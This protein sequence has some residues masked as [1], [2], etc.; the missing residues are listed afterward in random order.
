[1]VEVG[2]G[3][4]AVQAPYDIMQVLFGVLR[5]RH[6]IEVIWVED[7]RWIVQVVD[8]VV[9]CAAIWSALV[10]GTDEDEFLIAGHFRA[11]LGGANA[12][13]LNDEQVELK[14]KLSDVFILP[15]ALVDILGQFADFDNVSRLIPDQ[16]L[17]VFLNGKRSF[18]LWNVFHAPAPKVTGFR[19]R[20][21]PSP[22]D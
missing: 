4:E 12:E 7:G 18:H 9:D 17:Q 6:A 19:P 14:N 20:A 1:M 5:D 8:H 10:R 3:E 15:Y 2:V 11:G 16:L 22:A 21:I 13:E